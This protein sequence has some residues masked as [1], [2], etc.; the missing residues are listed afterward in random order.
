M[1]PCVDDAVFDLLHGQVFRHGIDV[2]GCG[3]TA[4]G[5]TLF[6]FLP[7]AL[8][9]L[10]ACNNAAVMKVFQ[11]KEDERGQ[12]FAVDAHQCDDAQ[13]QRGQA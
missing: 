6:P 5:F 2:L 8:F 1:I 9:L 3:V 11:D 12:A 10:I 13:R 4:L 7:L